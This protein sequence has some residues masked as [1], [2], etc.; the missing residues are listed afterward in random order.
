MKFYLAKDVLIHFTYGF[1]IISNVRT[2]E[3]VMINSEGLNVISKY[4]YGASK[5]EWLDA[6][7]NSKG[8]SVTAECFGENGLHSDPS[9]LEIDNHL[10]KEQ[11]T[12]NELF[13]LL[14]NKHVLIHD[15]NEYWDFFESRRSPLDFHRMGNFH[16]RVGEFFL[17]KRITKKKW[18]WWHDQK[19]SSD[20]KEVINVFYK[21]QEYFIREY[22]VNK[23]VLHNKKVLDFGCGN[24]YFSNL[25]ANCGAV[26][27]LGIDTNEELI[28]IAKK[29]SHHSSTFI[30]CPNNDF[31]NDL[32]INF[33]EKFDIIFMQD[34]LSLILDHKIISKGIS[35]EIDSLLE[36]VFNAL[37]PN[38]IF[39]CVDPNPIFWPAIRLGAKD[40]PVVVLTEYRKKKFNTTPNNYEIINI[41]SRYK[42]GLIHLEHPYSNG[43]SD[44]DIYNNNYAIWDFMVFKKFM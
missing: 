44:N 16:E 20:G 25:I 35:K 9:F 8:K 11:I 26:E 13:E 2:R 28:N 43:N 1:C 15:E 22:L 31:T 40:H 38:G 3:H 37:K 12:G 14:V 33:V 27:V 41:L 6:L 7:S 36:K 39:I 18:Q 5:E 29:N 19:F 21:V 24:G 34:V 10:I 42:L 30:F 32:L 4:F 17:K 23:I